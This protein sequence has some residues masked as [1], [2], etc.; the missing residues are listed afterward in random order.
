MVGDSACFALLAETGGICSPYE[1]AIRLAEHAAVNGAVFIRECRVGTISKL[2]D[3]FLLNTNKGSIDCRVLINAAGVNADE[4]HNQLSDDKFSIVPRRGEYWMIDKACGPV[5]QATIFQLPTAMGKGVLVT[6]TVEGTIIIGPSAEDIEDK[7]DVR[8]TAEKLEQILKIAAMSWPDMPAR[9]FITQFAGLRAHCDR[10]DF[11]IGGFDDVPGYFAAAGIE[12][13]GLTAAP[14]IA[15]DIAALAAEYL[16]AEK[17][18]D[19]LPPEPACPHFRLLGDRQR[20]EIIQ[21]N[22]EY[23]RIIC[24]CEQVSEAEIRDSIRRPVGAVSVDGVKRRTRAG[25]GRCQG[26]FCQPAVIKI[27]A[28]EL[29][30]LPTQITKMGGESIILTGRLG[31]EA[32]V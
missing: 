5:F 20:A 24:R 11:I 21:K 30:L 23:G 17:R 1:L 16:S 25:M 8:T 27:L 13:P 14:A 9:Q 26:G 22:P 12:S 28:E 18:N 19:F 6:P 15:E 2:T 29:N 7:T 3:G 10:G 31:G 4:I 32:S